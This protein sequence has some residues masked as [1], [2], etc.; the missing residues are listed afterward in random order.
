MCCE[1]PGYLTALSAYGIQMSSSAWWTS[2]IVLITGTLFAMWIGERITERGIGNGISLLIMIG[3]IAALP[4]S[5]VQEFTTKLAD[6]GAILILMLIEVLFLLLVIL[7]S[8]L[9]VQGTR[10]I[11]VQFAKRV[12]GNRQFEIR[13]YIPLKGQCR[14]CYAYNFRTSFDVLPMT[15][16]GF[17]G[18]Q[19]QILLEGFQCGCTLHL[20]L[21][22]PC[23]VFG[24]ILFISGW[25]LRL[26]I[27]QLLL[28]ILHKWLMT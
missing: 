15:F 27:L 24:I 13:Q 4:I 22:I 3:I 8:I 11:P 5:F 12:V 2:Y 23:L 21:L 20:H 9:L 28:L 16:S 18:A 10:K 14:W 25:L 6:T 26:H 7:I 1:A 19:I 17:G